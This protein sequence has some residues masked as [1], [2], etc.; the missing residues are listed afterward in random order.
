MKKLKSTLFSLCLYITLFAQAPQSI[1]YQAIAWNTNNTPRTNQTITIT[2]NIRGTTAEG[3]IEFTEVHTT[4]TNEQGLFTLAIGSIRQNDFK[5]IDWPKSPKFLQVIVD[6][7]SAGTTQILSVPYALYAERTNL[8]AGAGIA[9]S[10]NTISNTGDRDTTNEIQT[11]SRTG[12]QLT[13]SKNGGTVNLP[14]SGGGSTT[15]SAGTGISISPTNIISTDLKAGE[16]ITIT[17]NTISTTNTGSGP[18]TTYTAGKGIN[19]NGTTIS[20][21]GD[22]D[23][24]TV[25]EIQTLSYQNNQL[26][27]SKGGGTVTISTGVNGPTY[28]AGTGISINNNVISNTGDTDSKNEIQT[29]N[30]TGNQ[31]SLSQGGGTVDLTSVA[32][33]KTYTAGTGISIDGSN[34]I[35]T[36]HGVPAGSIMAYGGATPPD[37][38]LLCD[39]ATKSSSQYPELFAAIGNNWGSGGSGSFKLPDLRGLFLRGVNETTNNDLDAENRVS[40]NGSNAGNQVGSYQADQFQGHFHNGSITFASSQ[41]GTGAAAGTSSRFDV[42]GV[43]DAVTDGK[44]DAPRTGKE[45]RPKNVYVLYII[46]Y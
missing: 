46:K 21:T 8:K 1:N 17:G 29:L 6:G 32:S 14:S 40:K 26:T 28:T 11:L 27:L 5:N 35:S 9:I 13:L 4:T 31:L 20:N 19:I 34:K 37:G 25:N 43:L 7:L 39:G 16:G 10:G 22:G 24:S 2:F 33:N 12:N 23:T 45:T 3:T 36:T 41:P 15:Y 38:W 44:N 30:L 42:P 18:G